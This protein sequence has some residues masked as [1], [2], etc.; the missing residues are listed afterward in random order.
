MDHRQSLR[1]IAAGRIA[2]GVAALVAP[3]KLAAGWLGPEAATGAVTLLTRAFGAR[4]VAVGAGTLWALDAGGPVRP[5]VTAG[6]VC[7]GLDAAASVLAVRHLGAPKALLNG[8]VAA[9]ATVAGIAA[10]N[11]VD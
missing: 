10:L 9:S 11:A 8:A 4:E 7:D 3:R 5:W 1:F 6:V 2:I